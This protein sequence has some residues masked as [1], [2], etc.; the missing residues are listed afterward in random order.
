MWDRS[1]CAATIEDT[2]IVERVGL[3]PTLMQV[4]LFRCACDDEDKWKDEWVY[5][6]DVS[7]LTD[8]PFQEREVS[9]HLPKSD[10]LRSLSR[11]YA[12][13][14]DM[15]VSCVSMWAVWTV[16]PRLSAYVWHLFLSLW[17]TDFVCLPFVYNINKSKN[18]SVCCGGG[19][20]WTH[21]HAKLLIRCSCGWWSD[22]ET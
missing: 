15:C 12:R 17:H 8:F 22:R 2:K 7:S 14:K 6:H 18:E 1:F 21:A 10:L 16:L 5:I 20:I 13:T 11:L 3:E 4:L 19:G 9:F